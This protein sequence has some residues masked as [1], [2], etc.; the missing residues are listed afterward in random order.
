MS[1]SS[2]VHDPHIHSLLFI[3]EIGLGNGDLWEVL[4][5]EGGYTFLETSVLQRGDERYIVHKDDGT[6]GYVLIKPLV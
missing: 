1:A 2:T 5:R 6:T 3:V 4:I